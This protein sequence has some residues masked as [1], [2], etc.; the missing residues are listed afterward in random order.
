MKFDDTRVT[1]IYQHAGY[2]SDG[3][4]H[5]FVGIP[6][7]MNDSMINVKIIKQRMI[8]VGLDMQL[9]EGRE[10]DMEIKNQG[11]VDNN[12]FSRK[13]LDGAE[14]WLIKPSG[15]GEKLEEINVEKLELTDGKIDL[16]P[17]VSGDVN[18]RKEISLNF[19]HALSGFPIRLEL[20]PTWSYRMTEQFFDDP[21]YLRNIIIKKD[22]TLRVSDKQQIILKKF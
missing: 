19:E 14:V 17:F 22:G 12:P 21:N 4:Y 8:S 11:L 7:F 20:Q 5:E 1:M 9:V 10:P 6:G 18:K 15:A 2:R 16:N 13:I 3:F